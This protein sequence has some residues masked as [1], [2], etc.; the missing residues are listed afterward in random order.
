M[1][2]FPKSIADISYRFNERVIRVLNFASESSDV[3]VHGPVAAVVVIAP[4]FI[5]QGFTGIDTTPV[6]GHQFEQ[7]ILFESQ[8]DKPAS[9]GHLTRGK[10]YHQAIAFN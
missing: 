3:D 7:L 5:K 9:Y 10:V 6:A 1:R 4:D 8:F 2:V